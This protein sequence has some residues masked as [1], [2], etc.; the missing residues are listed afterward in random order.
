MIKHANLVKKAAKQ[1][2]LNPTELKSVST[3]AKSGYLKEAMLNIVT[4]LA[5]KDSTLLNSVKKK[6]SAA[7][8][9]L[10]QMHPVLRKWAQ[11]PG[12]FLIGQGYTT[13]FIIYDGHLFSLGT[14]SMATDWFTA[15]TDYASYK[16]G[17]AVGTKSGATAGIKSR[18][19][20]LSTANLTSFNSKVSSIIS[21]Y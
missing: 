19:R 7:T 16:L 2:L 18:R 8:S 12:S 6:F 15:M 11:R 14:G 17:A 3:E 13:K 5:A 20:N 21:T 1:A 10:N 4:E 9:E